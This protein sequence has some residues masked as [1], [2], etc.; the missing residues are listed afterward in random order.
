MKRKFAAPLSNN[1]LSKHFGKAEYFKII[2]TEN[3]SIIGSTL[4]NA[5]EHEHGELPNWVAEKGITHI[6]TGGIGQNAITRLQELNINIIYGVEEDEPEILVQKF[7]E[8]NLN[9]GLN[10]CDH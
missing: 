3:K 2:D 9:S 1:K 5:P 8:N 7:L 10:L 4:L 6:I